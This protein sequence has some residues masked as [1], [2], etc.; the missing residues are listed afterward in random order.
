MRLYP[1]SAVPAESAPTMVIV[2]PSTAVC[3]ESG[4]R[5]Q[6]AAPRSCWA[7]QAARFPSPA[8]RPPSSS[9]RAAAARSPSRVTSIIALNM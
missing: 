9:T 1:L 7:V 4:S 6:S 2:T 8:L 5:C 3:A